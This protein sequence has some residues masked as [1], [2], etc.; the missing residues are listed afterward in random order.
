MSAKGLASII[1]LAGLAV[2]ASIYA[3][4]QHTLET[5]FQTLESH[6]ALA[7]TFDIAPADLG[8][9]VHHVEHHLV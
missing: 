8:A 1:V 9:E 2:A 3:D 5:D 7:E 6:A 4:Y